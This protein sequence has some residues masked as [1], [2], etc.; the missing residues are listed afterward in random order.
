MNDTRFD[1]IEISKEIFKRGKFILIFTLAAIVAG[2]VFCLLQT[3]EYTSGTVFIVKS[4]MNMD[5]NHQFRQTAYQ[6]NEFFATDNDVDHIATIAKSDG[7]FYFLADQFDLQKVYAVASRDAAARKVRKKIKFTRNDTKNI[8][9]YV[10][11]TDPQ[12]ASDITVA[13]RKYIEDTYRN[14]FIETNKDMVHALQMKI[15]GIDDSLQGLEIRIMELREKYDAYNT[16]LPTRGTTLVNTTAGTKSNVEGMEF[17][18]KTTAQKD[19]LINDRADYFSL[20]N[21]YSVGLQDDKVKMFYLIQDAY[22]PDTESIPNIPL[23][24]AICFVAG[25]FFSCILVLLT[26]YYKRITNV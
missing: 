2:F 8:E 22:V 4:P 23:T 12:R 15:R 16:L 17:L 26:A 3:K 20:M 24:L 9:L 19:K 5:R 6:N 25:L 1:L 10:T 14:F 21:E 11:D 7:L 18:Q 13:T